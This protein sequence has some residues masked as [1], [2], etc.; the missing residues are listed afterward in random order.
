MSFF[1]KVQMKLLY[2]FF[3][4]P[5]VLLGQEINQFDAQGERHGPWKKKYPGTDQVKYEGTFEHGREVGVFKFYCQ[6]CGNQPAVVRTFSKKDNS[7]LVQYYTG[8]GQLV[9]EGK[10]INKTREGE[11]I[12]YHKNS[13][14]IMSR[15][16]FNNGLLDGLQTTY[17]P[18]GQKTE[19]VTYVKG[20][21]QGL[22]LYYSPEGVLIKKLKYTDDLLQGPAF[23]YDSQ[24][25]L[26]VEG[27]YKEDKKHG[28]WKYYKNGTL[29][30]EET[31]P[32]PRQ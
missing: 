16:N 29:E 15:E 4:T 13:Q 30:L 28:L 17:Y 32:K 27:F 26:V 24:G 23:Y 9:S 6:E 21:K 7:V 14:E 12:T 25:N 11:W 18:T 22:H 3:L 10:M 5:F 20:K 19:E 1:K 31:Y 2:L 8:K